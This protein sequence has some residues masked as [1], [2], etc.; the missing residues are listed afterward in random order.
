MEGT[1]ESS[2]TLSPQYTVV[3]HD[4]DNDGKIDQIELTLTMNTD[5]S[6]IRNIVLL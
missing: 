4:M 2:A 1:S 5:P 3:N 6:K